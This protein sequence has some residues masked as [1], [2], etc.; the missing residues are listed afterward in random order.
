MQ[1]HHSALNDAKQNARNAAPRKI[2]ANLPKPFAK[3]PAQ[4]HAN[5][6]GELHVLYVLADDL[7]IF[8]LEAL[9]PLANRLTAGGQLIEGGG[10]SL[11]EFS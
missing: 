4:W 7:S 5:R 8:G 10:Q 6:L 11:H 2:A 1:K 3:R 9:K